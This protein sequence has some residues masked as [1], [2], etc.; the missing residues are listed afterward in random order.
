MSA[1]FRDLNSLKEEMPS[2]AKSVGTSCTDKA[3]R[4]SLFQIYPRLCLR[5]HYN[6]SKFG[7]VLAE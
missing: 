6:T 5:V 1:R 7:N 4:I 2:T 3:L